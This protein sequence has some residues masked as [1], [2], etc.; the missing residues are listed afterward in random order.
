[1]AARPQW[2]QSRWRRVFADVRALSWPLFTYWG[3]L[4]LS[5][6]LFTLVSAI[7]GGFQSSSDILALGGL[8]VV[9][10][11]GVLFGQLCALTG[12]RTWLV[13]AAGAAAEGALVGLFFWRFTALA[14]VADLDDDILSIVLFMLWFFFPFFSVAGLLSLRTSL[15]QIFALFAPLVWITGSIL[16]VSQNMTDSADR[17][18]AGDK[19]AI[20]DVVT[21]P[22]L[23]LGIGLSV[24]Y[25]ASREGHRIYRWMTG[26]GA[27]EAVTMRRLRG[28]LVGATAT[29][30]GSV[31]TVGLLVLMVT[32]GT[33]LLAPYLWRTEQSEEGRPDDTPADGEPGEPQPGEREPEPAP[34]EP[35]PKP[36]SKPPKG[37]GKG[38]GK[39]SDGDGV[40]DGQER[41]DGTDPND[42]DSDG[43]GLDDGQEKRQGSDPLEPDSDGDGLP[44]GEE[45]A[46][47]TSPTQ[48]DSDGDGT[49][50]GED[51]AAPWQGPQRER[52]EQAARD[53]AVSLFF[54]MLL[55]L[56]TLV[57]LL[58][59]GPPLRRSL[60]LQYLRSPLL[61]TPPSERVAHAWR[62]CEVA[63]GD[64]GLPREPGDTPRTVVSKAVARLPAGLNLES[65]VETAEIA[66]RVRYGLGLDPQDEERAR[67]HAEMA[68]QSVWDALGE[69]DK[70]RAVYRWNL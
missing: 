40:P 55:V 64:L 1:M 65:L 12:I 32:L 14:K 56:L 61:P 46:N 2:A 66:D 24:A 29:G 59:F 67:R 48:A 41:R 35:E 62:L 53:T 43:D 47:G 36:P 26:T 70:V 69:W 9:T 34:D 33:G 30:C 57:G 37:K 13:L 7:N 28:S 52:L 27:A 42:P 11:L 68:Y 49:S 17:W 50:D 45:V 3:T 10:V 4:L 23:L 5:M 39:D 51:P 38:E 22:I 31:L 44:D 20:W 19:W 60:L 16:Y 63:L 15:F 54:L 58:V 21:A 18:F 8:W 6:A 25:L